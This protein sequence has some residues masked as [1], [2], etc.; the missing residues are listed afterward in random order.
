M[1]LDRWTSFDSDDIIDMYTGGHID[2]L[3]MIYN[4][5]I[6]DYSFVIKDL[7]HTSLRNS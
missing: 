6:T 4:M 3:I 2:V 1:S 7:Q 5:I